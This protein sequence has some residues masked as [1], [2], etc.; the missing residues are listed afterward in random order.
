MQRIQHSDRLTG[1][2][3]HM[4]A[5]LVRAIIIQCIVAVRKIYKLGGKNV[6][7]K[8]SGLIVRYIHVHTNTE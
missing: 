4:V 5:I 8:K 3:E 2:T 6:E 7:S 1:K